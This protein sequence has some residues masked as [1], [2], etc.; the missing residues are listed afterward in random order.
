MNLEFIIFRSIRTILKSFMVQENQTSLN[1][2]LTPRPPIVVV[3]GHVDHG[4]TAILDFIKKTKVAEKEAGGITQHIGA[5]EIEIA[6][7]E[8]EKRKI[9]FIDTPGHEAFS[10]MRSRGAK[11]ADIAVLVI[12]ADEGFKPQTKEALQSIKNEKMPFVIALNKIDKPNANQESVKKQLAENEVYIEEWGGKT[13]LVLISAKTGQGIDELLEIILLIAD[14]ENFR[15]DPSLN[16]S[17]VV[18]ESHLD[19]RRGNTSTLIIQ[20]GTLKKG[21]SV[22]AGTALASTKIL[23]DFLGKQ[24]ETATFSSPVLITGFNKLPAVGAPF[25]SFNSKAEAEDYVKRISKP[26]FASA[27]D[28]D[29]IS[30]QTGAV[31]I[32][33]ILKTDNAGSLEA[34][35]E[36]IAKLANENI[37]IEILSGKVGEINEEDIKLASSGEN[38]LIAGFNVS[39]SGSADYLAKRLP[40]TIQTFDIIY[41][42]IDWLKEEIE[43]RLPPEI[44]EEISGKAEILKVFK[45]MPSRQIAG[46]KVVFG[47]IIKGGYFRI[48]KKKEAGPF[49]ETQSPKEAGKILELEQ[50]KIKTEE[51]KE[52]NQF[53]AMFETKE[54]IKERDI[55]EIFEKKII[56]KKIY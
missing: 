5:Y 25:Q 30:N 3:M 28:R 56:K 16:G 49:S 53:G 40:V 15:A 18:I 21:M 50:N 33:I 47:K 42:L 19:S 32:H 1:N 55:V 14:L 36:Q 7:K 38:A 26:K 52:G 11:V 35:E 54:E 24:L 31:E 51:V 9:T 12:A 17:G 45:K 46:G 23:E 8:E 48:L 20:N 4:K 37:K 10:K 27:A 29:A 13:P 22:A 2:Q 43:K 44:K 34:L 41:K 6:T 39:L